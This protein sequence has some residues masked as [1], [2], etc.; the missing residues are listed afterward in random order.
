[1]TNLLRYYWQRL[2]PFICVYV[3]FELIELVLLLCMGVAQP[4]DGEL[5]DSVL[6][7]LNGEQEA[8]A[9]FIQ[10]GKD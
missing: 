3:F 5:L 10:K 2:A 9:V 6:S 8:G 4:A 7:F 1:M